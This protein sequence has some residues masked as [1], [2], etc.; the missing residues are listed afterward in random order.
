MVQHSWGI[1]YLPSGILVVGVTNE[2]ALSSEGIGLHV[3]I[4]IGDIVHE[5]RFTDVGIASNDKCPRVGIDLR[6]SSH[7]LSDLL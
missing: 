5:G 2:Q 7:V 3:H 4:S 1:D 6:E